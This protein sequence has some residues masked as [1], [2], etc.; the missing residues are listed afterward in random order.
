MQ[1]AE[2]FTDKNGLIQISKE[3]LFLDQFLLLNL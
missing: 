2:H 3:I 1:E